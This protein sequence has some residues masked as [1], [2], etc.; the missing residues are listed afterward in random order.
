MLKAGDKKPGRLLCTFPPDRPV[1]MLKLPPGILEELQGLIRF[2]FPRPVA[3]YL[4]LPVEDYREIVL[5]AQREVNHRNIH[6]RLIEEYRPVLASLVPDHA[7]LEWQPAR[8]RAARPKTEGVQ[9]AIGWHRE[10]MYGWGGEINVWLPIL[11][12]N[13]HTAM[14]YIEGSEKIP[15]EMIATVDVSLETTRTAH[16]IGLMD[17]EK[18][19]VGGVDFSSPRF[20]TVL[21]GECAIFDGRLIHG[22]GDNYSNTIRFSMDFRVTGN[23]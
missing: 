13:L 9:E 8:L 7:R 18:R 3:D 19:I 10:S 15:D 5:A 20:L 16:E 12:V 11:N 4:G 14:Q 2:F 22:Q 17:I 1:L 21:P 6:R 23:E